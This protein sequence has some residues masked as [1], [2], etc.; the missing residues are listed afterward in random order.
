MPTGDF[1]GRWQ[2]TVTRDSLRNTARHALDGSRAHKVVD[3][4]FDALRQGDGLLAPRHNEDHFARI[5][6]RRDPYSESHTR[7]GGEIVV[8]EPRIGQDRVV[9]ERLDPRARD[10]RGTGLD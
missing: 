9:R 6:D 1:A 10:E 7:N 2:S 5:H 8:E 3:P 4:V